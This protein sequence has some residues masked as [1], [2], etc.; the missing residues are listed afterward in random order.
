MRVP[1]RLTLRFRRRETQSL[2]QIMNVQVGRATHSDIDDILLIQRQVQDLHASLEP[3]RY[4]PVK[5]ADLR[6]YLEDCMVNH[7]K[8]VLVARDPNQAVGYLILQ[9]QDSP[10]TVF[11][12]Q[13]RYALI[14]QM[15]VSVAAQRQRVGARLLGEATKWCASNGFDVLQLD[16]RASNEIAFNFYS[17]SGFS[18]IRLRMAKAVVG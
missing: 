4:K 11:T 14:D 8:L 3:E 15:G 18:A 1:D 7:A 6:A 12:Y 16:V 5:D 9:T 17:K 2:S 13:T 10:D